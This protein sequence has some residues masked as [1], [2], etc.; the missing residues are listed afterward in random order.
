METEKML[1]Q[2]KMSLFNLKVDQLKN[3]KKVEKRLAQGK[4]VNAKRQAYMKLKFDF[5]MNKISQILK[6]TPS[7]EEL[8]FWHHRITDSCGNA[9]PQV[10]IDEMSVPCTY[11]LKKY[12]AHPNAGNNRYWSELF[13]VET[14]KFRAGTAD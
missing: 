11:A 3:S 7:L 10:G 5:F 8:K 14:R 12:A 13:G 1:K 9:D 2:L 4:S 6:N